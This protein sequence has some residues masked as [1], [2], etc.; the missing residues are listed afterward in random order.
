MEN[1]QVDSVRLPIMEPPLK[2]SD[3]FPTPE[4]IPKSLLDKYP[5][6]VVAE[7]NAGNFPIGLS[8]AGKLPDHLVISEDIKP[9]AKNLLKRLLKKNGLYRGFP[10]NFFYLTGDLRAL[11]VTEL[12]ALFS[13]FPSNKPETMD[14]LPEVVK[15][16]F[17]NSNPY[18]AI[19]TEI[20][21]GKPEIGRY[22][23]L[24]Q[25]LKHALAGIGSDQLIT[26]ISF[27]EADRLFGETEYSRFLRTKNDKISFIE[28]N[29]Q[30]RGEFLR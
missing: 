16:F 27:E 4:N 17:K 13:M 18:V 6:K 11:P 28:I 3:H 2:A 24:A 7:V 29:P 1:P 14:W 26:E 25:K 12:G 21:S 15:H 20:S 30:K 9:P 19:L 5:G 23:H 8:L 10:K 22:Y